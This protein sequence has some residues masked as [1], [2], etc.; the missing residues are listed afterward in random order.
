MMG[1]MD[2]PGLVSPIVRLRAESLGDEGRRWLDA[3]PGLVAD[4]ES[5]WSIRVEQS[6]AGGTAAFVAAA[7]T[8]AGQPVVLKIGV[9]DPAVRDE[10]GTLERAQGRGY[11]RLLARDVARRAM[12]LEALGPSL[13]QTDLT[14]ERQLEILCAL[15]ATAWTVPRVESGPRAAP[16]NKAADLGRIVDRLWREL[17]PD[18]PGRV[19]DAA[20]AC[21]GRRAAAFDAAAC[22]VVHG[23]AAAA[24]ALRVLTPRPG[25][26]TGF[27]FVDPDGF[28][29]DPAYDLGVALRDWCSELL[30]VADPRALAAGYG[31][32]LATHSGLD[33][34]AIW[35]WGYLER[36][37]TGLHVLAI[38]ATDLSRPFFDTARAL[39]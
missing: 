4:L 38:G 16:V 35:E 9:A 24:N 13:T 22:V 7:R 11:V 14:P 29:G 31:E 6:L 34:A 12:L 18:C 27:V 26:D 33:A 39:I 25:A 10:I 32:I 28:V 8:T 37:S 1:D 15:A 17:D 19:R 23:D 30:A 21:A 5:R 2:V 20:L 36:V 3:L